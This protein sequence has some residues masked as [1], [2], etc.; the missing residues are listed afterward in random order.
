MSEQK[1]EFQHPLLAARLIWEAENPRPE[2]LV[3]AE[4]A[5]VRA[6]RD[7]GFGSQSQVTRA[8]GFEIATDTIVVRV[9]INPDTYGGS[10]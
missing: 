1:P 9:E 6:L 5:I 7:A 10:A 2:P 3:R 8:G 4:R